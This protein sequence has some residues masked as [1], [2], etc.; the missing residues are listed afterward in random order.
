MINENLTVIVRLK[1]D[2]TLNDLVDEVLFW[3]G[4]GANED[5][6]QPE[7]AFDRNNTP[8]QTDAEGFSWLRITADPEFIKGLEFMIS[9]KVQSETA[10][11][12]TIEYGG[13]H[14]VMLSGGEYLGKINNAKIYVEPTVL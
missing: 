5:F 2:K 14:D 9:K 11:S 4:K 6:T 13:Q 3:F 12:F 7:S 10:D 1:K 8:P